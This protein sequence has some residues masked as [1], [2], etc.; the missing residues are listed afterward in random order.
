MD[1]FDGELWHCFAPQDAKHVH[2]VDNTEHLTRA[3]SVRLHIPELLGNTVNGLEFT[4]EDVLATLVCTQ[5][6]E[7]ASQK[8]LR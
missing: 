4:G 6:S 2:V 8:N 7:K 5:Y 1:P 3:A